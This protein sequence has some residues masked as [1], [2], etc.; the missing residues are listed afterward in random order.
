ME[1][2]GTEK[3][4]SVVLLR[5]SVS[6]DEMGV[7]EAALNYALERLDER[8][9]AHRFGASRDEVE[10]MRDDLRDCLT[11]HGETSKTPVPA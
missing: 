10:G 3:A 7:Y 1:V 6:E 9:I 4:A 5:V 2:I 8:T 11:R